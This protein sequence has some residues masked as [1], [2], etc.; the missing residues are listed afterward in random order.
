M[1]NENKRSYFDEDEPLRS[2][3]VDILNGIVDSKEKYR[4]I[5]QA[6]IA[7]WV[8][9]FQDQRIEIR[10]IDDLR[11]LI[12]MDLDIQRSIANDKKRV[13]GKTETK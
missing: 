1:K 6:S 10:T 3:E 7:R 5:I 11:K 13:R 4:R 9:D 8:K 2:Q 12:E